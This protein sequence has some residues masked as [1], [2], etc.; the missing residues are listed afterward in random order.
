MISI[1]Q[2]NDKTFV[3]TRNDIS[4]NIIKSRPKKI[5]F[6]VKAKY[7]NLGF[8]F[9]KTMGNGIIQRDDGSWEITIDST[10]TAN[11]VPGKYVCDVKIV[12][13]LDKEYTIIKPQDFIVMP[14]ATQTNNQG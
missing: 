11:I 4:G 3:F 9:Q 12:S 8:L 6:T 13:E 5:W 1:Y 7:E 10:D 2:G 14:V